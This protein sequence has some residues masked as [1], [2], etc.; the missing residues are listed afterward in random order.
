LL[1]F[2]PVLKVF[3]GVHVEGR[4][5]LED[6]RRFILV[7]NHNSHLDVLLLFHI[8]PLRQLHRT[9][10][11]AA[12]EYFSRSRV[13]RWLVD[14]LLQPVWIVRGHHG[15]DPLEGMRERLAE[16]HSVIIFPEGTRGEAG[17]MQ[18]FKTGVGRL[19]A[20][21]P[22]VPV[23]PVFLSGP[24]RA[25]PKTR[26]LLIP[27][28]NHV[29]V[30]RPRFYRGTVRGFTHELEAAVRSLAA[31]VGLPRHRRPSRTRHAPALAVLGI[32]GSGKSTLARALARH[33]S[34]GGRACLVTD[35]ME[36][37]EDGEPAKEADLMAERLRGAL[38]R[39]SKVAESLKSYRIPKLAELL[40]R[41]HV[42]GELRRWYAPDVIV[43][44]GSPL[45]NITA[46]AGLYRK[47]S[48]NETMC[49]SLIRVLAGLDDTLGQDDPVYEAFP[50]LVTLRRLHVTPMRVPDAVL[51]L[52]VE[53]GLSMERI[54]ARGEQR[55]AHETA[56]R[57]ERLREGY[58]R[59]CRA[60]NE[61]LE[62]PT[63]TLDGRPGAEAVAHDALLKLRDMN[64]TSF[65]HLQALSE[66]EH[67]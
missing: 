67:P 22:E 45:L 1:L 52:D 15:D 65:A 36:L 47:E 28:W 37:F 48:P 29:R 16:G 27:V 34:S 53:P 14:F 8:L 35:D 41:D 7:A 64:L 26:S 10:P 24:E 49:L 2:R 42:V 44:D 33:L 50:D 66:V 11:V 19:A 56:E 20:E 5:H 43:L 30:G 60:V 32:D 12:H 58:R 18:V 54:D 4:E 31:A 17:R 38:G 62:V 25:L 3:F 9:H 61:G 55:Q 63:R 40:L 51:F 39:R 57:L 23:V 13:V 46:W 21:F 59:V 6:L